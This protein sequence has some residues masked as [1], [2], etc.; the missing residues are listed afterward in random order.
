MAAR[1]LFAGDLA[2]RLREIEAQNTDV[3]AAAEGA[4]KHKRKKARRSH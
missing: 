1:F 2:E 3:D 4:G